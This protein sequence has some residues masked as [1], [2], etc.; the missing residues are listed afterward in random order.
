M[1]HSDVASALILT[2]ENKMRTDKMWTVFLAFLAA[3]AATPVAALTGEPTADK[4]YRACLGRAFVEVTIR[5]AGPSGLT[6]PVVLVGAPCDEPE[7]KPA[8]RP[9]AGQRQPVEREK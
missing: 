9:A 4:E 5:L 8:E 1:R 7:T 3:M 6:D 2:R